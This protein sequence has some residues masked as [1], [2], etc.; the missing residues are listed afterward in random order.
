MEI[1]IDTGN[2]LPNTLGI[3]RRFN[4]LGESF[5][6]RITKE[7]SVSGNLLDLANTAGVSVIT[8]ELEDAIVRIFLIDNPGESVKLHDV[9]INDFNFG[10]GFVNSISFSEGND[11]RLKQYS[12]SFT[13]Y[14]EGSLDSLGEYQ[15]ENSGALMGLLIFA[16]SIQESFSF[17]SNYKNK[18]YSHRVAMTATFGDDA[19]SSIDIVKE[20]AA[21]LLE[22]EDF[23]ALYWGNQKVTYNTYYNENFNRITGE[24]SFEKSYELNDLESENADNFLKSRT[25]SFESDSSGIIKVTESAEFNA[26]WNKTNEMISFAKADI[27]SSF[28]RCDAIYNNAKNSNQNVRTSADLFT[29]PIS[30]NFSIS[31]KAGVVSYSISYTNDLFFS[32]KYQDGD[33]YGV[34]GAAYWE[35]KIEVQTSDQDITTVNE[36]GSIVGSDLLESARQKQNRANLFWGEIKSSILKGSIPPRVTTFYNKRNN[37]ECTN[38]LYLNNWSVTK[39]NRLGTVNY[40]FTYT[41]DESRKRGDDYNFKSLNYSCETQADEQ[42]KLSSNVVVPNLKEIKQDKKLNFIHEKKTSSVS[43]IANSNSL[44]FLEN[45]N[46]LKNILKQ[47]CI[48]SS[49]YVE[50][51]SFSFNPINKSIS[52]NVQSFKPTGD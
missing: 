39:S 1:R 8:S 10:K 50:G 43:A 23:A 49:F 47:L 14:E 51:A 52:L 18:S 5:R 48:D 27:L 36:S 41:D 30:K 34:G 9:I 22:S 12:A 16:D 31:D 21:I 42:I 24:C 13:I 3:S 26:K 2:S 7:I 11:V 33:G 4:F 17:N 35:Y 28:A 6:Y 38:K 40:S 44:D 15:P 37:K 45:K 32:N 20:V 25:H 29:K 19:R 46:K